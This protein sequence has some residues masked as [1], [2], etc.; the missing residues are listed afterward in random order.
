LRISSKLP[1]TPAEEEEARKL[2]ESLSEEE[3]ND[4]CTYARRYWVFYMISFHDYI[5][6]MVH[7][8]KMT[9]LIA[10]AIAGDDEAFILAAQVDPSVMRYIPYFQDREARAYREGDSNFLEKLSYRK[11]IPPLQSKIRFP[12]LY[13]L[14]AILDG[15]NILNDMTCP[16][17]LDICD[18]AG[19]DRWQN[20]IEDE[21][22]L[23]K[24]L[25]EYRRF[26]DHTS[27]S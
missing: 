27:I 22:Y 3:R 23:A 21:G 17:I 5:A 9:H 6:V 4:A 26:Q 7:R 15:M 16:E 20:R 25:R 8:R 11:R 19:L 1:K 2:L 18:A 24:R 14:F 12:L 13:L 10:E